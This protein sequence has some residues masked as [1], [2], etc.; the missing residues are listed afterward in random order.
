M[1]LK[2]KKKEERKGRL[3]IKCTKY[4][5]NYQSFIIYLSLRF[6]M[7]QFKSNVKK[8][9]FNEIITPLDSDYSLFAQT[10]VYTNHSSV[11]QRT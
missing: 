6:L 3:L 4:K 7:I 1:F 10:S 11:F 5:I 9:F 8:I 2:E